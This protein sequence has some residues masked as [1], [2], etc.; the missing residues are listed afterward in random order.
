MRGSNLN[1]NWKTGV[2]GKNLIY[3]HVDP[4]AECGCE[5]QA[6]AALEVSVLTF[7]AEYF[8]QFLKNAHELHL[9]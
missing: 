3:A 1:L 2:P 8:M 5:R 7:G 6:D 4:A 9:Q